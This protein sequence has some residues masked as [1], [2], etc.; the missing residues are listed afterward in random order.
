MC[1]YT[2]QL[3]RIYERSNKMTAKEIKNMTTKQLEKLGTRLLVSISRSRLVGNAS[4]RAKEVLAKRNVIV[5]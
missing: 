5:Y 3:V 1:F 2:S 4:T